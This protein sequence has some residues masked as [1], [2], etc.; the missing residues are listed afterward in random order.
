M[1]ALSSVSG[2][3]Q[4]LQANFGIIPN[5]KGKGTNACKVI[6]KVLELQREEDSSGDP[7][8][9]AMR[10]DI[11]SVVVIDR[12]VD[13]ISP[14]LTPLTYESLVHRFFGINMQGS[15]LAVDPSVVGEGDEGGAS[16]STA[17]GSVQIVMDNSDEIFKDIR[18][19]SIEQLGAFTKDRTLKIKDSYTNFR[20]NKDASISEIHKFVKQIPGLTKEY[21]SLNH[22]IRIAEVVKRQSDTREFREMWQMERGIL[23]GEGVVDTLEDLIFADTEGLNADKALCLLCLH[24]MTSGGIRTNKLDSIK[25]AMIQ[26]YGFEYVFTLNSLERVGL[27]RRKDALL[28]VV[29][30]SISVW[31]QVRKPLRLI[32][33]SINMSRPDDISYVTAGYAPLSVR[34]LQIFTTPGTLQQYTNDLKHLPGPMFEFTQHKNSYDDLRDAF[35]RLTH[36]SVFIHPSAATSSGAFPSL[37]TISSSESGQKPILLF[38]II[39]G[40]TRLEIAALRFLTKDPSFPYSILIGCTGIVSGASL[41]NS[42]RYDMKTSMPLDD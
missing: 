30:T 19:L 28:S 34:L 29:D 38:V 40:I 6:G 42:M 18:D 4:S 25:R 32:N 27:V 26:N 36:D 17:A 20:G 2:A 7:G 37:S 24:S 8:I 16:S 35:S 31:H 21:K 13:L 39:G 9:S 12:D 33:D 41:V 3:I 5:V 10:Q 15:I 11:S 23:E 14:F 22:H 1:S